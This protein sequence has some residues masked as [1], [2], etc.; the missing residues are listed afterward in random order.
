MTSTPAHPVSPVLASGPDRRVGL[1]PPV[2]MLHIITRL[3]K[4]GADEN[5]LYT[6]RGL[7]PRRYQ[8]DLAVGEGSDRE[9]LS[10]YPS[11]RIH[12]LPELTRNPHPFKDVAALVRLARLIRRGGYQIVHTHTTKAGFLGRLAAAMVGTPI[13]VHT[14][15]GTTFPHHLPAPMR[16]FY[17]LLERRRSIPACRSRSSWKPGR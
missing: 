12:Y 13:I 1:H 15:H 14:V 17:L 4:G 10:V 5:T 16:A 9:L 2:R 6:V 8:V 3:I 11:E 7:D